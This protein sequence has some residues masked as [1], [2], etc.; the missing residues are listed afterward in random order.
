MKNN[1]HACWYSPTPRSDKSFF[2]KFF[3]KIILEFKDEKFLELINMNKYEED[4]W[5]FEQS[6][7][8][9]REIS[10]F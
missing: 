8:F 9:Y 2:V 10:F 6:H 1:Y 3:L 5:N 4:E 7:Y